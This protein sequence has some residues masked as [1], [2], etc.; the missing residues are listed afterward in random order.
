M[1][2]RAAGC[3]YCGLPRAAVRTGGRSVRRLAACVAHV[4]LLFCDPHYVSVVEE[5]ALTLAELR[6]SILSSSAAV[7]ARPSSAPAMPP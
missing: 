1:S 4:D 2:A 5:D 3:V 6:D 7:A